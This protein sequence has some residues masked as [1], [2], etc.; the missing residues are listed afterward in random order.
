MY[1]QA[2]KYKR[3]NFLE[4]NNDDNQPI[5]LTYSKDSAWLKCFGLSNLMCVYMTR[6]IINHASI[7]KYRL[8]FFPKESFTCMWGYC[9]I[10]TRRHILFDC[11]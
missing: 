3:R 6:L 9:P 8:R 2:S 7:D 11:A 10:E 4:L 5:C 1:F